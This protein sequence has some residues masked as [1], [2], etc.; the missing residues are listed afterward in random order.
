MPESKKKSQM[1]KTQN[2][3]SSSNKR[4]R[5]KRYDPVRVGILVVAALAILIS[6]I[7]AIR[8]IFVRPK[9]DTTQLS[10]AKRQKYPVPIQQMALV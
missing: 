3:S 6:F 2:N 4:R 5:K 1:N 8:A 10:L 9:K 7:F